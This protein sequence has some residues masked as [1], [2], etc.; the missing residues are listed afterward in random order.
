V[1]ERVSLLRQRPVLLAVLAVTVIIINGCGGPKTIT[2]DMLAK[3]VEGTWAG[4]YTITHDFG[5]ANAKQQSG[6]VRVSFFGGRY[7]VRPFTELLPPESRGD[8][9]VEHDQIKLVNRSTQSANFDWTLILR[10]FFDYQ[11]DEKAKKLRM[12]QVDQKNR[13]HVLELDLQEE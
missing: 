9:E 5:S 8:Y 11:Y 1:K 7:E 4:K 12:E 3:Q 6:T 10:G 2:P 13:K